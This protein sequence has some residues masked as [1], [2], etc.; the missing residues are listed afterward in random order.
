MKKSETSFTDFGL[1]Y[2][3]YILLLTSAFLPNKLF[4]FFE[5]F[6]W[7]DSQQIKHRLVFIE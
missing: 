1:L 2:F 5:S 3:S 6:T 4:L 7:S